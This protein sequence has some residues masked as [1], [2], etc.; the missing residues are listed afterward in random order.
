VKNKLHLE[1]AR[2]VDTA[3][4]CSILLIEQRAASRATE[5]QFAMEKICSPRDQDTSGAALSL[6]RYWNASTS[7]LVLEEIWTL[8]L[9]NVQRATQD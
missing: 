3:S 2:S 4:T 5:M 8:P 6:T 9:E 7:R 1:L